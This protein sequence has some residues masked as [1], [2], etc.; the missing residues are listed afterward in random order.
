MGAR[1]DSYLISK[2]SLCPNQFGF[3]KNS[4]YWI[5]LDYVYSSL[6]SKQSTISVYPDFS[7][8]LDTVDHDILKSKV[9]YNGVKGVMQS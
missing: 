1:L 7:K 4:T 9:V 2:N 3:Y 6:D 5:S 8:P